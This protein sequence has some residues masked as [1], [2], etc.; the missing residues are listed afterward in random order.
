MNSQKQNTNIVL[1]TG[2]SGA[3]RSTAINVFEDIGY[4][5]IDN[6]P[7]SLLPKLLSGQPTG[8][9]MA[10][11]VDIRTRDF[12]VGTVLDIHEEINQ[13]EGFYST[14]LYL[15]CGTD[16]LVRRYSETRRRHPLLPDDAPE[17]GIAGEKK[18]LSKLQAMADTLIDTSR[19]SPHDLKTELI[20]WYGDA[21]R[22]HM[23]ITLHSFSYKRGAPRGVD[24]TF[25]CRF[26]K[27]P[28]WDKS[29]RDLNGL[30]NRVVDYV[31]TDDRFSEF[32]DRLN[33][34]CGFLLPAY[35]DEGKAHFSIGLGCTGGQHRSVC[36]TEALG[37]SLADSGWHV[38]IRHRELERQ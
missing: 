13:T 10:L 12:N 7:L 9:Q 34:L 14:I 20:K 27:N 19:L 33:G 3:G 16:V 30:D 26:L 8:R 11:G 17:F 38:S 4:E 6:M 36:V 37:K 5:T 1:V 2:P 31:K 28:Y 18:I 25:D 15:D 22:D 29:L 32:F 35:I 21:V 24:M 23:S